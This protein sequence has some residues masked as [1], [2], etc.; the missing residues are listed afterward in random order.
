MSPFYEALSNAL[1][2]NLKKLILSPFNMTFG[3]YLFL[4]I[5]LYNLS[6]VKGYLKLLLCEAPKCVIYILTWEFEEHWGVELLIANPQFSLK[7]RDMDG[8]SRQRNW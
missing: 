7:R 2:K 6:K 4:C 3:L 5:A 1:K 8:I